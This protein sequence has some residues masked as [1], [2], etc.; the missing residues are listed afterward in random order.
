VYLDFDLH[1]LVYGFH[2]LCLQETM[3]KVI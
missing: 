1:D 2:H 3:S